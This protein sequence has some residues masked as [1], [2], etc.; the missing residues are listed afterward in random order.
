MITVIDHINNYLKWLK[1]NMTQTEIKPGVCEITTPFLD[2]HN[3]YTQIYVEDTHDGLFRVSDGGYTLSDLSMCGMEFNTPKKKELLH[4][5]LNRLGIKLDENQEIL[6]TI[7]AKSELPSIQHRMIQSMLDINDMFY[8]SSPNIKSLFYEDVK[9]F[10]DSHEIYYSEGMNV[11]GKS[12][13]SHS[14]NFVLQRNKEN[15]QRFIKL[16]NSVSRTN[17]ERIIF[18]WGDTKEARGNDEKL[19]VLL[20]DHQK[21]TDSVIAGFRQYDIDPLLWSQR[22]ENIKIFA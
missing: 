3:D 17:A 10:F 20:N 19:I 14:Y 15:P 9:S 11:M 1:D 2:R 22:S 21:V 5:S 12:G 6:Y 4:Q 18:S 8:L 7:C 13:F 16:M